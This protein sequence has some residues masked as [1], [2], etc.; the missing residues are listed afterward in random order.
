MYANVA[1]VVK[2]IEKAIRF[3]MV[4]KE[5]VGLPRRKDRIMSAPLLKG[6]SSA[7]TTIAWGMTPS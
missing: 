6:L 4:I 7:N 1:V 3:L 5:K 2:I